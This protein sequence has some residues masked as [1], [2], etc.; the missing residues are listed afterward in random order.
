MINAMGLINGARYAKDGI[1]FFGKELPSYI[2]RKG[3]ERLE[4]RTPLQ[5]LF[6]DEQTHRPKA[7]IMAGFVIENE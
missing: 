7:T 6:L 4:S 3:I 1:V 2:P 5:Q